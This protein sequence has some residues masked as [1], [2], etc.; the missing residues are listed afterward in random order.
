MADGGSEIAGS[1]RLEL[2]SGVRLLHPEDAV[3]EA[4]LKGWERQQLGGKG[5]QDKTRVPRNSGGLEFL[6]G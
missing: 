6:P 5:L 3:L 4:M 2:I 1:A